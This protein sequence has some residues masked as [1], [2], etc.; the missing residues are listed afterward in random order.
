MKNRRVIIIDNRFLKNIDPLSIN[1][2]NKLIWNINNLYV[3]IIT[4]A[5]VRRWGVL[6]G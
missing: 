2:I 4:W 6:I 5:S 3:F 1:M